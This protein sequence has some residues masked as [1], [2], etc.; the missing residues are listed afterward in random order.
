VVNATGPFTDH[1]R[2]MDDASVNPIVCP[3]SGVHIV[4]P[5]YYSPERMG[6][7]DPV[8]RTIEPEDSNPKIVLYGGLSEIF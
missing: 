8:I 4:L 5:D 7:L 3:S 6:L 2:K 1:I